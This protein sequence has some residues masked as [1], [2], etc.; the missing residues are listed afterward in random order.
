MLAESI[1]PAE[2]ETRRAQS[3]QD[4]PNV[5]LLCQFG[6][7]RVTTEWMFLNGHGPEDRVG[8]FL[9]RPCTKVAEWIGPGR[10]LWAGL[11]VSACHAHRGMMEPPP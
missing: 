8:R 5:R 4:A 1:F 9:L 2:F 7:D 3:E 6:C 10:G 11:L